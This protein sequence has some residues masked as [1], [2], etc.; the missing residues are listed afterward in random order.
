MRLKTGKTPRSLL[1]TE[2]LDLYFDLLFLG[3]FYRITSQTYSWRITDLTHSI[4]Y[5]IVYTI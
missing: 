2:E 3:D 5:W 4:I 1:K